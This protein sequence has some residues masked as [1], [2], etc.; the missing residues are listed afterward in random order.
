LAVLCA[1]AMLRGNPW[2][3][4]GST[5]LPTIVF[6]DAIPPVRAFAHFDMTRPKSTSA[7]DSSA[8]LGFEAK[9][10]LA[11]NKGLIYDPACGSGG[12]F[13]QSEKFVESHGGQLGDISIYGQES[14]PTTRRLAIMNLALRGIEADF[15]PEN[16]DTFR[17]DL[18]PDLRADYVLANPPFNDSDWFRKDDDVRWQF[19]VPP[20]GNAN[21]AWVQH[22]IHHL[23]PAGMAGFVLANG[24]MSSNQSGEGDIRQKLIEADLVDCMV[25][26]P[27]K[28][29][30]STPIP[31]CLWFLAKNKNDGKR[32]DRRKQMLFIDARKFGTMTGSVHRE[33]TEDDIARISGTYHAWRSD[34]GAVKYADTVGFCKSTTLDEVRSHDYELKPG[35]F[36]GAE[37][38]EEDEPFDTK[39]ERLSAKLR[40]QLEESSCLEKSI[41]TNLDSLAQGLSKAWFVTGTKAGVPKGW[42]ASTIKEQASSIQYGLTQSASVA[43]IGPHFLRITDIQ[44]GRVDWSTVPF[45][46]VTPEEHE[47]YRLKVGDI[48]VARTGASTGEN[49]YLVNAPDSVFAS[50]LV[51]F[52]FADPAVARFVGAFMRSR[53]YFDYVAGC[54]GGSAQPN[55]SAQVLA[56]ARI[57]LPPLE[58]MRQ[59]ADIVAPLDK[60][61]VANSLESRTLATLRDTLLPKLLS[62]ELS[63][64]SVEKEATA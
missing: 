35:R 36:V 21:F 16:A 60:R 58:I 57:I 62:G 25:A 23:A 45:C 34:K 15:G 39:I 8:N 37:E 56:G 43:R 30:Y 38:I 48:L 4:R 50:Y 46:K 33:L 40:E 53:A 6:H 10:W 1:F 27:D 17:R 31:V 5:A 28:L 54:L 18:H 47:R 19:G 32:R 41:R 14:N 9:R 24:S 13:V 61:I 55:A 42:T 52:Q 11:R 20:K 59:F 63:V 7:K 2:T 49:I 51:R 29:F 22:F 44:G 3:G 12:M 26:L 64:A